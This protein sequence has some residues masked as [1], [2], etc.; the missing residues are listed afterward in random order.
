MY[1]LKNNIIKVFE[2]YIIKSK[3]ILFNIR[4]DIYRSNKNRNH[5]EHR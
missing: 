1:I 5:N 4:C 3:I 2:Y